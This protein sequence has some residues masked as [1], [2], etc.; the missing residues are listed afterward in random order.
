MIKVFLF[1]YN[2]YLT[3]I[4]I[5]HTYIFRLLKYKKEISILLD[6][7]LVIEITINRIRKYL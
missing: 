1:I 3:Y 2:I 7:F 6:F 5:D 4:N